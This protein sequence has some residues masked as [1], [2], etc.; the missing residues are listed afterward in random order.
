MGDQVGNTTMRSPS[1]RE[2]AHVQLL[3]ARQV[4]ELLAISVR[5]LWR[6]VKDERVP[7]PI[8]LG[9][10]VVRWR[11]RDIERFVGTEGGR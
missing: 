4:A 5:T 6:C 1:A 3:N 8:R 11:L 9:P 10:K 2:L 7:Q